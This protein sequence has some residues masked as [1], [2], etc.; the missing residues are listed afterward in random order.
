MTLSAMA[1]PARPVEKTVTLADGTTVKVTLRGDETFH[2]YVDANG[3]AYRENVDGTWEA[4]TRDIK[5]L[6]SDALAKRNSH[7]PQLAEHM[8]RAM[9]APARVGESTAGTGTKK[10]LLILVNFKDKTM[11]NGTKSQSIYDQMMNGLNNPYGDNYGSV[12]EYFKAQS[13]NQFDIIFDV[14]GPVT[15]SQKMSYYGENDSQGYDKHPEEMIKEACELA[16]SQVNFSD[17]DWDGDGEVENIY[18]TYAGYSEA[19]GASSNTI[20]PHQYQLEEAGIS[21]KLDGVKINTYACGSE[22]YGT[23]GS[24]IDGIG[25]MCHEYSHCL[26]LPDFYD[27]DYSGG[28]GMMDWDL[29]CSGSYNGS[30][31]WPSGYTAYEREFCGWMKCTELN[32][33]TVITDMPNI[34]DN[35]VAYIVK[36]DGHPDE[37]YVLENHQLTGW[38]KKAAGHGMLIIHVD[39]DKD[40][41]AQNGPNDAP[42]RQ[43]MTIIPADNKYDYETYEGQ[44]EYYSNDGDTWPGSKN[45]T[46]L[47]D[48]STPKAS[49]YNANTDGKKLMH[50]EIEDITEKNGLIS[51]TFMKSAKPKV[52]A[53]TLNE[54]TDFTAT[55]FTASWNAVE[56]AQSYN[57]QYRTVTYDDSQASAEDA[58]LMKETFAGLKTTLDQTTDLSSSLD[59]YTDNSGWT[60]SKVYQGKQ[61]AKLG[62]SS[63]K[64]VLTSP[65]L[66]VES[67]TLSL[68]M[69]MSLYS[70]DTNPIDIVLLNASGT[71]LQTKSSVTPAK[72][73]V[74]TFTDVPS[75]C[76][77]QLTSQK[78][79]KNRYY[80][81]LFMAFDGEF[82][83][84]DMAAVLNSSSS[85]KAL[86]PQKVR[87]VYGAWQSIT[88][89]T[90]TR[91]M[92]TGLQP[93]TTYEVQVQTVSAEGS[94]DWSA[95]KSVILP[96]ALLPG[97]ANGDGVV[98]EEDVNVLIQ[99][100][101]GLDQD[102][103]TGAPVIPV[104]ADM[105]GDG[106]YTIADLVGLISLVTRQ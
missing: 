17:Y 35:P 3:Q 78:T 99:Y 89:L 46:A 31:Y 104:A 48:T 15:V 25:T 20:W 73:V 58:L 52:D 101:L 2:F 70:N 90:T 75:S 1:I 28:Q 71:T 34:E 62:S 5:T 100:V 4:D 32:D 82:T 56:N 53:P 30:G 72:G 95:K 106:K 57:L 94:S 105:N 40:V 45:K 9:K 86:A 63:G 37:Y 85:V 23:S 68:Y 18:V 88:G 29:M 87:T 93:E 26:G 96:V 14:V 39:Y 11:V 59:S 27:I 41:W 77:V 84:D 49:L 13:Y 38:D 91:H 22:L 12:R 97:D 54:I 61:G 47:T 10:A 64:G 8:R 65:V 76:K 36:N 50:K 43:R 21:L 81:S 80:V 103:P 19:V 102:D 6:W 55:S 98:D 16:N 74:V 60:G 24:T 79:S 69:N 44:K 66:S 83:K 7:R 33:Y 42:S 51:F 67:G 92:V